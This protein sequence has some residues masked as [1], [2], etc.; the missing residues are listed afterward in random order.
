MDFAWIGRAVSHPRTITSLLLTSLLSCG[1]TSE[2]SAPSNETFR[3]LHE[4]MVRA[5]TM[6]VAPEALHGHLSNSLAGEAL[7]HRFLA[8]RQAARARQETG[9]RVD[10]EDVH[11]ESVELTSRSADTSGF[12]ATWLVTGVVHHENHSHRR[13]T[14]YSA[15]YEVGATADGPRI[16][17]EKARDA[18]RLPTPPPPEAQ[19]TQTMFELLD[20]SG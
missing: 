2:W 7:T 12:D 4:P 1:G 16:T 3:T 18:V 19:G 20:G 17:V 14:R 13:A 9:A 8:A 15:R 6:T 10:I 5:Q 11:Y